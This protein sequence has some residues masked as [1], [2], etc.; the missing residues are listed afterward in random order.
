[1]ILVATVGAGNG[2]KN[3]E[4]ALVLGPQETTASPVITNDH[5][6]QKQTSIPKLKPP[7]TTVL[8]LKNRLLEFGFTGL[9]LHPA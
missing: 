1:M 3:S 7:A 6:P 4:G 5:P 2:V 9:G 8:L